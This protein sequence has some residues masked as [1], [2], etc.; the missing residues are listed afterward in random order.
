MQYDTTNR[1]GETE[2][3]IVPSNHRLTRFSRPLSETDRQ[4]RSPKSGGR[5][6]AMETP[7]RIVISKFLEDSCMA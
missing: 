1:F 3:K 5:D 4:T 6:G 7:S 2:A